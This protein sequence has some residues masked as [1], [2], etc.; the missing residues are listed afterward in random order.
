M[1]T[2][3][4]APRTGEARV[5][6]DAPI[7]DDGVEPTPA[8]SGPTLAG[9]AGGAAVV[10]GVL[11][12][13]QALR[14]NSFLT[15]LAT[16]RLLLDQGVP[17]VD[18]YSATA[19]GEPWVVQ[20]W[21][22]SW[23]YGVAD[24]AAGGIG[25]RVLFGLTTGALAL[26]V[27]RLTRPADGVIARIA[28]AGGVLLLGAEMWSERPLL[29]GLIGM[30]L[31]LLA[32]DGRLAP[33]WLVPTFWLWVNTHGSFPLGLAAL[34]V[35][36]LG[37]TLDARRTAARGGAIERT[38]FGY[39]LLGT[40]AGAVSPVG[41][42][43]LSFPV[44]LLSRSET[45]SEI[46]EWNSP[47]FGQLGPRLFLGLVLLAIVAVA[48]TGS[49]RDALL[50]AFALGLALVA[51]RNVA[52]AGL[53]IVPVLARGAY[54]LTTLPGSLRP[55]VLG[56]AVVPLVLLGGLLVVSSLRGPSFDLRGYPTDA[57]VWLEEEELVGNGEMVVTRD[58]V[59]NLETLLYGTDAAV[60]IDDR[61]DMYPTELT[62]DYVA[63]LRGT[64]WEQV[65]EERGGRVVL[66]DRET[67]LAQLLE[68][69][70]DWGTVWED[71]DW[72]VAC[73]RPAPEV[74]PSCS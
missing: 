69:S 45:L 55:R 32:A 16:G 14:D 19:A 47:D 5:A 74:L 64:G 61:Y 15:H 35:L 54:G 20:S 25:L 48:R 46:A 37:S 68:A 67:Q 39:A 57:L 50:V 60:F 72:I 4:P 49:R 58:F 9:V 10:L 30:A 66:W 36:W 44:A 73:R 53:L 12:G 1:T 13:T 63:L 71:D 70:P 38:A 8:R 11:I 62:E 40:V 21:L 28:I 2:T 34:A 23:L 22:A 41:L 52:V 17:S 29:F 31:V 56:L 33:A 59:G 51:G 27:W 24:V 43:L 3:A 7:P 18:P 42:K 65:L 26:L 6:P